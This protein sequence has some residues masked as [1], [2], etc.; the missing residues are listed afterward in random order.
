[1]IGVQKLTIFFYPP[2][3]KNG[4]RK[5][6]WLYKLSET[7]GGRGLVIYYSAVFENLKIGS[8]Q[9]EIGGFAE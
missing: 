5:W 2:V 1:M 4:N 7:L 3:S 6:E 8:G 9:G